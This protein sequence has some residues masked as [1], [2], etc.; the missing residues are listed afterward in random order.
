M[1][2]T[3]SLFDPQAMALDNSSATSLS[4]CDYSSSAE[5]EPSEV[6][7]PPTY[8]PSPPPDYS[9]KPQA[10]E[11]CVARTSR[12]R[13]A[14]ENRSFITY[15]K[16]K[17]QLSIKNCN[18]VDG[19]PTYGQGGCIQ[20]EITLDE[21]D[22]ILSVAVKL[23]GAVS[24]TPNWAAGPLNS[25]LF[26]N[27]YTLWNSETSLTDVCP[28]I[29]PFYVPFPLAYMDRVQQRMRPLPPTCSI[30]WGGAISYYIITV[31]VTFKSW[32]LPLINR[33]AKVSWLTARLRYHPIIR[34]PR[35]M[36]LSSTL[37]T[38]LQYPDEWH[39]E[40]WS[41][42]W[43]SS[44]SEGETLECHMYIPSVRVFVTSEAIP[45][46]LHLRG[47][48][49]T[50][51]SLMRSTKSSSRKKGSDIYSLRVSLVRQT[52][53][54]FRGWKTCG[55]HVLDEWKLELQPSATL[56]DDT[57]S[58]LN[59]TTRDWTGELAFEK[60][61]ETTGFTTGELSVKDYIRLSLVTK[62][63]AASTLSHAIPIRLVTE[64]CV[65]A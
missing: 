36:L 11:Q 46:H 53:I 49:S 20:G 59:F 33:L 50:I 56:L 38:Y 19:L 52:S 10:G 34:P 3:S 14:S 24:V 51:D 17:I 13:R 7:L 58:D 63:S 48:S 42:K 40:P 60:S 44:G 9:S 30:A 31:I 15:K 22:T 57:S 26:S 37:S 32:K 62:D 54:S 43:P 18:K 21:R 4:S 55:H 5:T 23:E 65:Y 6:E 29:V 8:S 2:S 25:V 1:S 35:P 12:R 64:H 27:M 41:L 39:H 16:P 47:L 45:F 28:S 61:V